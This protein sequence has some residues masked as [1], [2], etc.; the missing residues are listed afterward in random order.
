MLGAHRAE[1]PTGMRLA[2]LVEDEGVLL[3]RYLL[4]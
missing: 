1:S 3:A 4:V 2:R